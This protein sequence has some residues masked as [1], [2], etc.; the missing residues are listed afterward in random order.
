MRSLLV[1][2]AVPA[3]GK[4]TAARNIALA[5]AEGG[6][7]VALLETDFRQPRLSALLPVDGEPGLA[8]VL[9]G[10][11]DLDEAL[12]RV[13]VAGPR[14]PAVA[15]V[16]LGNG[17][18]ERDFEDEPSSLSVVVS[19]PRPLNPQALLT[20]ERFGNVLAALYEDFDMVIVDS[21]PVLA[22][23]DALPLVSTVDGVIMVMRMDST[24]TDAAKRLTDRLH[25]TA[26]PHLVGVI[27]NGTRDEQHNYT[28]YGYSYT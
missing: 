24:T 9:A 8:N 17:H 26:D 20:R 12:Q 14:V 21:P 18:P 28:A 23:A 13:P 1:T 5:Y 7:R 16:S 2:S 27:V 25:R 22:V 4:S 19:G 11:L 10:T 3:E 6:T 15:A